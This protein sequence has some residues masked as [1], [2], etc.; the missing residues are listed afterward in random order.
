MKPSG[1]TVTTAEPGPEPPPESAVVRLFGGEGQLEVRLVL[2][3]PG[4]GTALEALPVEVVQLV[5]DSLAPF[6]AA[7]PAG[8]GVAP[9][10][11]RRTAPAPGTAEVPPPV[12]EHIA[13]L[14]DRLSVQ[15]GLDGTARIRRSFELGFRDNRA[16]LEIEAGNHVRRE[17]SPLPRLGAE[18][19]VC[20]AG[21]GGAPFWTTKQRR[22]S[23]RC[24]VQN[25]PGRPLADGVV[26][27]DLPSKSEAEAYLAGAG[28]D[29][30]EQ[31]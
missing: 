17:P 3:G 13:R 19:S 14:G 18:W 1:G 12:P 31:I 29:I 26:G 2:R 8:P 5:R 25:R 10:R 7:N 15:Q 4:A 24:R 21:A 22:Y 9:P 11:A 27:R 6:I 20:L 28:F 23:V 16:R 30:P